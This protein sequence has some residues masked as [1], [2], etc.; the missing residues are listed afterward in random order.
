MTSSTRRHF[1]AK[2]AFSLAPLG[3]G[4]LLGN[5]KPALDAPTWN[6]LPKDPPK[7][8]RAKAMISV[9]CGGGPSQMDLFD[10]KP[11]LRKYAGQIFPGKSELKFDNRGQASSIVMPTKW[12]FSHAGQCGMH[13][14]QELLPHFAKIV[15]DVT[16]VRS[17]HLPNIRNHVAGMRAMTTGRGPEGW[18]S[19]GSWLLYGLGA[20]T[21]NLPAFVALV[22]ANNPPGSPFWDSR[23]L[24]SIYQGTVVRETEPRIANLAP[25][26]HL[27][28]KA[29]KRQIDL[30]NELNQR[31]LATH[32]GETDLAAR[33][34]SY[35]LAARMQTS[36][37][38]ALDLSRE[39]EATH[40]LYGT[41]EAKTKQMAEACLLARRLV[42]RGVR[43][44]QIWNYG[45]D[46]HQ[47][48]FKYLGDRCLATDQPCAALVTD[49]KSRGL[50]DSTIVQ[51]GGE[52]GRL[53]VVQDR[54]ARGNPGRDH[55][56][57]GFSIWMAGGGL[58]GGHVHGATDEFGH[59]AVEGV[60]TQHDFHATLLHLMGLDHETLSFK[61]GTGNVSLVEAGQGK[62]VEGLLA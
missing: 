14:N 26:A 48:I 20:E 7:S 28:G 8:P 60:V 16:L 38:D 31:H 22:L 23:H 56:T 49:L 33:I 41:K 55:N 59:Q 53:P 10:D 57:E 35:E 5:E 2:S 4:T 45:W 47:D 62:V 21:Q 36:A 44:V 18:P 6:L 34:A 19:L 3:L 51:W 12:E 50:L 13:I 61:H 42:E 25:A 29:Q 1:L 11:L 24:P 17:M 43:M 54:G 39:S 52:M 27:R 9:F 46:M 40:Q 58:K 30:L 15:D 37:T 32:S